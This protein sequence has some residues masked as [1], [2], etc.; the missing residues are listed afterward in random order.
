MVRSAIKAE[1]AVP[2]AAIAVPIP[3]KTRINKAIS[4]AFSSPPESSMLV[5]KRST[6]WQATPNNRAIATVL[7]TMKG[8]RRSRLMGMRSERWPNQAR[9]NPINC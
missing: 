2:P 5:A 7:M 8:V 9:V 1:N 3:T 4:S 6:S